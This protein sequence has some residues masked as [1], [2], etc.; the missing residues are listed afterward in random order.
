MISQYDDHPD[1]DV[2]NAL[3]GGGEMEELTSC[4]EEMRDFGEIIRQEELSLRDSLSTLSMLTARCASL[5]RESSGE[6]DDGIER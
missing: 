5:I 2:A 6:W 1:G 4:V 3:V